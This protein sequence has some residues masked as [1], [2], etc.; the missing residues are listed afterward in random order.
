MAK[1]DINK[2]E[3]VKTKAKKAKSKALAKVL[4]SKTLK[5]KVVAPQ[6][7]K[8]NDNSQKIVKKKRVK[9]EIAV[10]KNLNP[11]NKKLKKKT[12]DKVKDNDPNF[13]KW[14]A[15]EHIKT[16]ED[17][18][19]YYG[20]SVLSLIA[21]GYF[22]FQG[23][24]I[25][26]F[27]F[28]MMLIVLIMHI[29]QEPREIEY[30]IDLDGISIGDRLYKYAN[31]Q[32]FQV[33]EDEEYSLLKFKLKNFVLPVKTLFLIDLDPLYIRAILENFL[34]EDVLSESLVNYEKKD[35]ASE[36]ISDEDIER[37]I[38]EKEKEQKRKI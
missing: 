20:G 36:Y 17:M 6:K 23:S 32:S 31:I 12:D 16:K 37:L 34:V 5:K 1:K 29:L 30:K 28:T 25:P 18:I 38:I 4:N 33:I 10:A 27:T 22:A 7:N 8:K 9:K 21:I 13:A 26:V 2:K 3:F 15:P 35:D 11:E 19:L 14:I 24:F